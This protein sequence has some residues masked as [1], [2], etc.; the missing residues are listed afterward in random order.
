MLLSL[1]ARL[2]SQFLGAQIIP[3]S[4]TD[5]NVVDSKGLVVAVRGGRDAK[6]LGARRELSLAP[7]PKVCRLHKEGKDGVV[8]VSDFDQR[9]V[10]RKPLLDAE[11]Y[12]RSMEELEAE[13]WVFD[14]E[15]NVIGEPGQ[16]APAA[17]KP[18]PRKKTK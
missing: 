8:A 13:G 3:L 5:V 1:I 10:D 14:D 4:D 11:G 17:P 12:A 16:K 18:K 9:V 15:G 7:I 2:N 6:H